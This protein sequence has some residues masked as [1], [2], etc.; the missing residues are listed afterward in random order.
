MTRIEL[1][2]PADGSVTEP[3]QKHHWP[4]DKEWADLE[5]AGDKASVSSFDWQNLTI[6]ATDRSFPRPVVFSWKKP[7][8]S[9]RR[10][11][12]ELLISRSPDFKD[13]IVL[14]NLS[15]PETKVWHLYVDT[16][17][18]WK[19]KAMQAN[20]AMAESE[21]RRFR[22][23]QSPP[24]WIRVP[25]MTNVR[26]IGGWRLPGNRMVR[27]GLIYRSSEMNGHLNITSRGRQ[28]LVDQLGIRTDLDLRSELDEASPALDT[29][30]VRWVHAPISPYDCICDDAFRGGYRL[31]FETFAD[32]ANYPIIFHCVGGADRGGTVAFL[33]NALLGKSREFLIRD[34]ELT[35]LS[36]WGERSRSSEQFISLLDTLQPM[37]SDRMNICEQVENYVLSIG[38]AR[39]AIEAIRT[40]LT[41]NRDKVD[42]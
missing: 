19:V 30:K 15:K 35:T 6:A 33:L 16:G 40:Q 18:Y 7:S 36:V 41:A 3:L 26:D 4:I 31:I 1:I 2:S 17:Y 11:S 28:I 25:G 5:T 34:Y 38:L 37:G 24:R 27:Q 42:K 32:P 10:M 23:H 13:P 39:E 21:I 9:W 14:G 8:A 12:Y 20:K 29:Q 22:T